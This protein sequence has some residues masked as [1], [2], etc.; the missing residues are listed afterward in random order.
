[1]ANSHSYQYDPQLNS[2]P[3]PDPLTRQ[4]YDV[5]N[6]YQKNKEAERSHL[7]ELIL[8][9]DWSS[10]EYHYETSGYSTDTVVD[11]MGNT[12]LHL[13]ASHN[14]KD[15]VCFLLRKK[16]DVNVQNYEGIT[17]LHLAIVENNFIIIHLLLVAGADVNLQDISGAAP[18]HYAV[19]HNKKYTARFLIDFDAEVD[20]IDK[21]KHTPLHYVVYSAFYVP[22]LV[23][24]LLKNG[25]NLNAADRNDY[26]TL[27]IAC[28][29]GNLNVVKALTTYHNLYIDAVDKDGNNALYYAI[30]NNHSEICHH[31]MSFNALEAK[32][33]VSEKIG[34]ICEK[35]K[36]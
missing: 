18:L 21:D 25:A 23:E 28:M 7:R 26:T 10:L 33:E 4:M 6:S 34:T 31:L 8:A 24:L 27:H 17:P 12:A 14:F 3:P 2:C 19:K 16:A 36:Q 30:S 13:A 5:D 11:S 1:M 15:L 32:E 29:M 9:G 22:E 35:F 20:I